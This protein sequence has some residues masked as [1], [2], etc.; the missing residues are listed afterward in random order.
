MSRAPYDAEVT[1]DL[2]KRAAAAWW[3][4][5]EELERVAKLPGQSSAVGSRGVQSIGDTRVERGAINVAAATLRDLLATL[6]T[7]TT[8]ARNWGAEVGAAKELDLPRQ[9]QTVEA[10]TRHVRTLREKYEKRWGG[11]G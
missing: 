6:Q 5:S 11:R 1:S 10:Q 4:G 8:T 7:A 2:L 3:A 9:V